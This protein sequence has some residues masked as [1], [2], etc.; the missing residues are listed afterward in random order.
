MENKSSFQTK[1]Q[2]PTPSYMRAISLDWKWWWRS[3]MTIFEIKLVAIDGSYNNIIMLEIMFIFVK[4][5]ACI[6]QYLQ[7]CLFVLSK[8]HST[9]VLCISMINK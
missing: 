2:P 1:V 8:L 4:G 7:E 6:S 5:G 9:D 3:N